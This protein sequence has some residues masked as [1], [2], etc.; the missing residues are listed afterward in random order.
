MHFYGSLPG[1][2]SEIFCLFFSIHNIQ[3]KK[4]FDVTQVSNPCCVRKFYF[5]GDYLET[6]YLNRHQGNCYY[7]NPGDCLHL[8]DGV[9]P[10]PHSKN[11]TLFIRCYRNRLVE[12]G[13]CPIDREWGTQTYPYKENCTHRFAI[14]TSEASYGLLPSCSS[15]EDGNDQFRTRP[16]DAYYRCEGGRATAVKCPEHTYYDVISRRCSSAVACCRV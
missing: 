4:L 9:Y 12:E 10:H 6:K 2:N 8:N 14:S 7:V 11:L 3:L 1:Y 16:C 5:A 13:H 15:M